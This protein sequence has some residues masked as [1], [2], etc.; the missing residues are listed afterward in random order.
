MS[1][2]VQVSC[3]YLQ[4]PEI[5]KVQDSQSEQFTVRA[6]HSAA[7]MHNAESTLVLLLLLDRHAWPK[8]RRRSRFN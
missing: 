3:V 1:Q 8:E 2:I 6:I 7:C 4:Y 5:V